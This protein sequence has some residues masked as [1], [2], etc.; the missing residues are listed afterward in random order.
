[1]SFKDLKLAELKSIAE[2]FG[3]DVP[4]KISKVGL[5]LLLQEEGVSYQDYERFAG[6]EKEEPELEPGRKK[7]SLE[8]KSENTILVK[9]DRNNFS[10]NVVGATFSKEHPFVALPES[11]ASEIFELHTGFRPATPREV[12]EFYS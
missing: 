7:P 11:L 9:M 6:I 10:Y 2:G 5:T 4:L 12:Q 8:I 1:M 3:V